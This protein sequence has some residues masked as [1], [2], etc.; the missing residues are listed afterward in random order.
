MMGFP[1]PAYSDV[2]LHKSLHILSPNYA[3]PYNRP[4]YSKDIHPIIQFQTASPVLPLYRA[5]PICVFP[6]HHPSESK[7]AI[8]YLPPTARVVLVVVS[9]SSTPLPEELPFSDVAFVVDR[10]QQEEER[11]Q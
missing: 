6:I 3:F 2:V 4:G 1:K 11:R 7:E 5:H 8:Q 10:R 9:A